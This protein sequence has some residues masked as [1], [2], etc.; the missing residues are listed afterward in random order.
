M[1]I[2]GLPLHPLI[3]HATVVI[4]PLAAV[5]AIVISL[6][7][8]A[9]VRYSELVLLAAIVAPP[10]TYITKMA[11]E[12]L[13]EERF[14]QSQ[15]AALQVHTTLG[16]T[17]V[18]WTIGLLVGVV[19]VYGGQRLTNK[20][21]PRGRLVLI[22]GSVLSIGFGIVCIVQVIRIGHAGASA[23]WGGG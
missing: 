8:W 15:S 9:R 2:L 10:L 20:E 6:I 14:S 23:A 1:E 18:W 4:I 22:I 21:N 12:A 7:K 16:Q 11:G 3:V 19:L 5:G 13:Y 17:L